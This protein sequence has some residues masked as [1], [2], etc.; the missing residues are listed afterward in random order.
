[1]NKHKPNTSTNPELEDYFTK[2]KAMTQSSLRAAQAVREEVEA[3][4]P[5]PPPD[6]QARYDQLV[7]TTLAASSSLVTLTEANMALIATLQAIEDAYCAHGPLF[8]RALRM[9]HLAQEALKTYTKT[10]EA[11]H[12]PDPA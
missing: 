9:H 2:L 5:P 7:A 10:A 3:I 1:M 12:G 8:D 6:W 11:S 4:S